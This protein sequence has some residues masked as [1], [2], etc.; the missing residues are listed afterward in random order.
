MGNI[1]LDIYQYQ[2]LAHNPITKK[3]HEDVLYYHLMFGLLLVASMTAMIVLSMFKKHL[4][5]MLIGA[6]TLIYATYKLTYW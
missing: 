6:L 3:I 2:H 5:A 4:P 1:Y